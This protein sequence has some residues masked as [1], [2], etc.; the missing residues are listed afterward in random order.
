MRQ[1]AVMAALAVSVSVMSVAAQGR[2]FSGTWVIDAEKTAA[3]APAPEAGGG[4]GGAM[5]ESR[6]VIAGGGGVAV[7]GGV[8]SGVSGGGGGAIMARS[9]DTVITVDAATFTIEVGEV[10][11]SYP[12]NGT[13]TTIE[14]RGRAGRATA[15]WQGDVLTITTTIDAPNGPATSTQSW[16]MDGD[17][18]VRDTGRKTYYRRK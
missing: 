6:R 5:V 2:N 17:S 8:R 4:G 11:T 1:I 14:S 12:T 10:K 7:G 13:E 3:A 15:K 9:T 18:L 16:S